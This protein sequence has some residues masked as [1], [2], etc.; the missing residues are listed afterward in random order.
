MN[1][2]ELKK[3]ILGI[4][5]DPEF[6]VGD[7]KEAIKKHELYFDPPDLHKVKRASAKACGINTAKV[8]S[9]SRKKERVLARQLFFHHFYWKGHSQASMAR[10]AGLDHATVNAAVRRLGWLLEVGD[11]DATEAKEKF[12]NLIK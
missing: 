2:R 6:R 5:V 12:D 11:K 10:R 8:F 7:I 1:K 9:K 3:Q 4:I